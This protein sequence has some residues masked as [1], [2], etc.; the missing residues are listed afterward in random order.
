MLL[1]VQLENT[2]GVMGKA[3]RKDAAMRHLIAQFK[4]LN[5]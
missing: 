2:G 4:L 5:Q 1:R 3:M